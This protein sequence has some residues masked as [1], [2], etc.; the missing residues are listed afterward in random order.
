MVYRD[1][2][3]SAHAFGVSR[4]LNDHPQDLVLRSLANLR[5]ED[6]GFLGA[7]SRRLL[8]RLD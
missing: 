4:T 5:D 8:E 2:I 7:L 6:L 1:L 3:S